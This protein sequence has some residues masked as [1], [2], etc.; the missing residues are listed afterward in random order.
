MA[1]KKQET[2]VA[3]NKRTLLTQIAQ[4]IAST[5]GGQPQGAALVAQLDAREV[6][7]AQLEAELYPE[8]E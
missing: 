4:A 8:A 3:D 6:L 7:R 1:E 5:Q 2:P